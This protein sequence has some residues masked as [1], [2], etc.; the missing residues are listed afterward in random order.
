VK[1]FQLVVNGVTRSYIMSPTG[2]PLP[3]AVLNAAV[4]LQSYATYTPVSYSS[5]PCFVAGTMIL[6]EQG[7]RP[8]ESLAA[9]DKIV[10][11]DFGS[12]VLIWHGVAR[13]TRRDVLADARLL[14]VEICPGA[15][16]QGVPLR[17]V[18][19]SQQHRVLLSGWMIELNFGVEEALVPAKALLG[20]PGV[21]LGRVE[22][23]IDYHHLLFER[24]EIIFA[25][26]MLCESLFRP[27]ASEHNDEIV[28][29]MQMDGA[30]VLA[31]LHAWPARPILLVRE[32]THTGPRAA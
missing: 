26:G 2:G 5:I 12:Q 19:L 9:G 21:T 29:R 23:G 31:Q 27:A 24:H 1:T 17:T 4:R 22:D 20:M 11:A 8:V 6:T 25:D 18:R 16:G 7:E 15:L 13:L 28:R 3:G 32:Y 14:P 30:T 10:T